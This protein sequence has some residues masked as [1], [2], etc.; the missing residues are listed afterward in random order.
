LLE[1][2]RR[3]G[4]GGRDSKTSRRAGAPTELVDRIAEQDEFVSKNALAG[5]DAALLLK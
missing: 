2:G 3:E 4:G 5:R 1:E